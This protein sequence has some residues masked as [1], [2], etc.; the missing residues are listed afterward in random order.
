MTII[1]T[2]QHQQHSK[3]AAALQYCPTA[4]CAQLPAFLTC[5]TACLPTCFSSLLDCA[6]LG[7]AVCSA[8]QLCTTA[9]LPD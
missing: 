3:A 1:G 5:A 7:P 2:D 9:C 4:C 8:L 6:L